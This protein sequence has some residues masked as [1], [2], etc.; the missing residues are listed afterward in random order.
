MVRCASSTA[1]LAAALTAAALFGA[2]VARAVDRTFVGSAQLDY[3]FV[4]TAP[5][6]DPN[7]GSDATTPA[8][9]AVFN[10][11]TVEASIKLSADITDHVFASAKLCFGCHGLETDMVYVDVRAADELNFRFGHF[12]PTFGAFNP[13]HDPANHK[14]S[15]KPLPYDMGRML[16]KAD[17]NLGVLPSPFPDSGLEVEGVH[18]LGELV[19]FDYAVYAVQ[20]FRNTFGHPTDINFAESH[21]PNYSFVDDNALPTVGGHLG[22]TCRLG[23]GADLTVGASAM[24]GPYDPDD[25]FDYTILGG[26]LALRVGRTTLRA[27]YLARRTDVDTSD[28]TLFKYAVPATRGDFFVKHGAYVELEQPLGPSVDVILRGDGLYRVGNVPETSPLTNRSWILRETAGLAWAILRNVRLKG[29]I[30]V[31]QFRDPDVNGQRSAVGLHWSSV[32]TF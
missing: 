13:R 24:R 9:M 26:D 19:S 31:W 30:E 27:E 10:G 16:R 17:W 15:D 4:P 11:L 28:P 2:R 18:W 22:A 20:G 32:A 14:L 25:R 12:S 6:G 5:N 3:H 1:C 7:R 29:S 21:F 23:E 8:T